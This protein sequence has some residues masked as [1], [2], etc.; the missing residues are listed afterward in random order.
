MDLSSDEEPVAEEVTSSDDE[1][2]N[3][4]QYWRA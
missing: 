2:F 4:K 1:A 3:A